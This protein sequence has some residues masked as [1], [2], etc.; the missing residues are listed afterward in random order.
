MEVDIRSGNRGVSLQAE[1]GYSPDVCEDMCR[2][3][4]AVFK[5]AFGELDKVREDAESEGESA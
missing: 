2:H 3:A 4:V 5:A 1:G